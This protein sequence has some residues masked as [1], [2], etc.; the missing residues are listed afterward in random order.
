MLKNLLNN[1]ENK[2]DQLLKLSVRILRQEAKKLSI[3]LYSRK[4]KTLLVDLILKY[5]KQGL[6]GDQPNNERKLNKASF[7]NPCF[8]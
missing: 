8:L 4:N 5:Q 2:K 6:T 7:I 1:Y 3:P